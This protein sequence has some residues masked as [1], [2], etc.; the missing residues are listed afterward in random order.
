MIMAPAASGW[1]L[2]LKPRSCQWRIMWAEVLTAR[3]QPWPRGGQLVTVPTGRMRTR[4]DHLSDGSVRL[5]V[6]VH[7]QLVPRP[8]PGPAASVSLKDSEPGAPSE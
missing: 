7:A 5:G 3:G 1:H 4:N 2:G 6:T 8:G